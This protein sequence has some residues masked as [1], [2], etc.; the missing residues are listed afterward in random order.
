MIKTL[1]KELSAL[2]EI[3]ECFVACKD[4]FDHLSRMF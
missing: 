4:T 2:K 1:K 3:D